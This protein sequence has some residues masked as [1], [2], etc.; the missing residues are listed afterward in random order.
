MIGILDYGLGNIEAFQVAYKR[1]NM[2]AKRIVTPDDYEGVS[3]IILPG[4]GA[5][6]VAMA[7][8]HAS[9]LGAG[10][11]A[12]VSNNLPVMGI[13]VGMQMLADIS[14]E[15]SAKGLGLVPGTVRKFEKGTHRNRPLRCPHMGWNHVHQTAEFPLLDGVDGAK[16][17]FL[18]SYWFE[19]EDAEDVLATTL[20]GD[21]FPCVVGGNNIFGV[22]FHPEKSHDSGLKLLSNFGAL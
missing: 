2:P 10:L 4:V 22:Q 3:H 11:N 12:A 18:H 19:A 13:C 1:L 21:S 16:F 9:G 6:D 7:R 17:Y 14:D 5:F 20:Y 15:G 8:F